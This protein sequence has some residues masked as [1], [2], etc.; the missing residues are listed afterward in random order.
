M[1][2]MDRDMDGDSLGNRTRVAL[3]LVAVMV[4]MQ[5]R[6]HPG[7]PDLAQEL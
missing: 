2:L 1:P 4:G 6:L 5:N 3:A 7:D